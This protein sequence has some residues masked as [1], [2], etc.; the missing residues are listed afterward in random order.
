[1]CFFCKK[2]QSHRQPGSVAFFASMFFFKKGYEPDLSRSYRVVSKPDSV[3]SCFIQ[4]LARILVV[5]PP[6]VHLHCGC[7]GV[8]AFV[9]FFVEC[10]VWD[11]PDIT[12]AIASSNGI[13]R[14]FAPCNLHQI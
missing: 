9:A 4:G 5:E 12:S 1:M 6:M 10:K 14:F 7:C 2:C 8:V 11:H 3:T 13:A